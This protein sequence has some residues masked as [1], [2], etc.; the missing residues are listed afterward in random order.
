MNT[1]ETSLP[2]VLI[3][4]PTV[5]KDE[6]GFF[7]ESYHEQRYKEAGISL[8]FVQ[9]NHSRS[10]KNTLRGLHLQLN[11]PQGKLVRVTSGSVFDVAVDVSPNS[12]TFGKWVGL[13]LSA[14]N[15][16]QL[17]VPPGYAHGFFVLSDTAEFQY[18][19]T[20][21]YDPKDEVTVRWN[22]PDLGIDWP[23]NEPL[24]SKKDSSALTTSELRDTLSGLT[25]SP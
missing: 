8:P 17:Y 14:E 25:L 21:L 13:E 2:G 20:T 9:D 19:C 3:I 5:F 16:L 15:F 4:E 18:K 11:N 12:S 10:G 24:L 7:L 23:S 6:R 1:K 22:D